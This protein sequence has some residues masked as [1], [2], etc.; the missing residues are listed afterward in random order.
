MVYYGP[1]MTTTV[2]NKPQLHQTSDMLWSQLAGKIDSSIKIILFALDAAQ[3]A[4]DISP[5]LAETIRD[6]IFQLAME[7]PDRFHEIILRSLRGPA[8]RYFVSEMVS[9]SGG[10]YRLRKSTELVGEACGIEPQIIRTE[11]YEWARSG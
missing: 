2:E 9:D 11:Y 6:A 10:D 3:E 4:E 8:L 5:Y 1:Q 7:Y